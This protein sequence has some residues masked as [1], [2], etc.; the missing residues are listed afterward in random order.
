MKIERFEDIIAWQ[1]AEE[2]TLLVY[3]LFKDNRD[4]RFRDQIQS[5]AVSV[6]N[7]IAEGFERQNN[8]ELIRFLYISRGS[9]GE[10]RSMSYLA[11]KLKYI[12]EENFQDLYNRTTEISR[13]L[14]GFIKSI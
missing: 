6:M 10:V 3:R 5:A 4:F 1:K 9:S 7:N 12:S 8:K 2:L 14:H 13:I 11:L